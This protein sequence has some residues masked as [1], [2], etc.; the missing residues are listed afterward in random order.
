MI[1]IVPQVP[2]MGN[3]RRACFGGL[4]RAVAVRCIIR[5][6]NEDMT[7][8]QALIDWFARE[9]ELL[10]WR[11]RR[12]PYATWISEIM[13]QQTQVA[14]VIPYYERFMTQ[15]PTLEALA[16]SALDPVLKLWE[17]LGYYARARS[18]HRAARVLMESHGG[19]FPRSVD[20]LMTL[21]GVGRYTAGAILNFGYGLPAPIIDGNVTRVFCRLYDLPDDVTQP[22]TQKM[23]W[24]RAEALLPAEDAP[25]WN[26]GLMELGR[27]V[28]TKVNPACHLC[29]VR[30][31]CLAYASGTQGARPNKPSRGRTP[32]VDVTA[33][34]IHDGAGRYLIAQR[35][36]NR[37]LGGL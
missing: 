19:Q 7:L 25:L 4:R 26:E 12:D 8:Q 20:E 34:V 30:G 10:P 36:L 22:A 37:M 35:P 11:G 6:M 21:P 32:H 5:D 15:F 23:L 29:P 2:L 16:E 18:L 27:R 3:V 31:F 1:A 13:L 24:A 17:G 28:C 14:T 33:A 9:A